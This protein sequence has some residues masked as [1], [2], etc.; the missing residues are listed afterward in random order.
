MPTALPAYQRAAMHALAEVH[1]DRRKAINC[2]SS[3]AGEEGFSEQVTLCGAA[4]Y[5]WRFFVIVLCS[6]LLNR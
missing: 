4:S 3:R 5:A 2:W 6:P 1:A